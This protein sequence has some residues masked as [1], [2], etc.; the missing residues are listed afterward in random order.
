[1]L[2]LKHRWKHKWRRK[3]GG[4]IKNCRK[5]TSERCREQEGRIRKKELG[6]MI[7]GVKKELAEQGE[8]KDMKEEG[9]I[10]GRVKWKGEV[11]DSRDIYE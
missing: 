10:E 2:V 4:G 5:D 9:I 8:E 3:T 7:V 6:G 11:K 1:M